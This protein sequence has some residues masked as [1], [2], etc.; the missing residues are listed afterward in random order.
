[1]NISKVQIVC[2]VVL[3]P[4]LTVAV[5]LAHA[6]ITKS[7]ATGDAS[8]LPLNYSTS[9]GILGYGS[10]TFNLTNFL[11]DVTFWFFIILLIF[12]SIHRLKTKN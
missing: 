6:L 8:G 3:A 7:W 1:M 2:S 10:N 9:S 5:D 11:L 4:I 12:L